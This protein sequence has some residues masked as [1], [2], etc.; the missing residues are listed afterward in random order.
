MC[1]LDVTGS[2]VKKATTLVPRGLHRRQPGLRGPAEKIRGRESKPTRD[3][4]IPPATTLSTL[5][6]FFAKYP[7]SMPIKNPPPIDTA[8]G[9]RFSII[10]VLIDFSLTEDIHYISFGYRHIKVYLLDI[11]KIWKLD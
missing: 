5:I 2:S 11:Y 9:I 10:I 1:G 6:N 3:Q 7:S 8:V 4:T